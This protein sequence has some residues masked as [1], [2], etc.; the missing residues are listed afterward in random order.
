M[1]QTLE[2]SPR[3]VAKLFGCTEA[4][5]RAQYAAN[6]EQ[7]ASLATKAERSGKKV[8]GYTAEQL[9]LHANAF[10]AKSL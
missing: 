8:N 9:R 10:R 4:Q 2:G 7:L 5:A 6:A 1:K 3:L